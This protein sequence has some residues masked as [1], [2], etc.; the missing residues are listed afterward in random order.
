MEIK[1]SRFIYILSESKKKRK[2]QINA[3][4]KSQDFFLMVR[5]W[6]YSFQ[7]CFDEFSEHFLQSNIFDI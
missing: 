2:S 6:E 4:V 7:G 5:K 1:K 3:F